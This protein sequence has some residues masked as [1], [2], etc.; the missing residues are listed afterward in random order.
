M[1]QLGYGAAVPQ[2]PRNQRRALARVPS[3]AQPPPWTSETQRRFESRI[4]RVTA[5]A[6]IPLSWVD[7]PEV[8]A[9][10]ADFIPAARPISRRVLTSRLLPTELD[11]Q[12]AVLLPRIE[13]G[14]ATLQCDGWSAGNF[15]HYTGFTLTVKKEVVIVALEDNSAERKT[16]NN[17]LRM[18][19]EK[20]SVAENELGVQVVAFVSDDGGDARYARRMLIP[21]RPD[22]IVIPCSAHQVHL[23]SRSTS[24]IH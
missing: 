15:H 1:P 14:E 3:L 22:L 13:G 8:Q 11:A 17:L 10:F 4:A 18:I 9:F 16:G 5:S 19:I 2:V 20:I 6:N 7:D 12:R 21:R 24:T 23:S